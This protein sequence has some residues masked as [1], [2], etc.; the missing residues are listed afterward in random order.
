M[1]NVKVTVLMSVYN[2]E[3]YLREAM[4]SVLNQT[5]MDFEFIIV[6]DAS[7]D[8]TVQILKEYAKKDKRIV[9]VHNDKNLGLTKSLNKGI[10][11]AKGEYIARQDADDISVPER[12]RKEIE[13]L[14]NHRNY[15]V[16][17]TFVKILNEDSKIIRSLD[18]PI[19]DI[20][21]RESFR[22]DNCIAHGSVIIRK[23][24]L[25]DVG[26]YDESIARAQDYELWL[27]LAGKYRLA[28][29]PEYLYMLRKHNE[30]IEAKHIVEQKISVVLAM[31]KN[32]A[33]KVE[34]ATRHFIDII[35]R[36]NFISKY[37]LL[38]IVFRFINILTFNQIGHSTQYNVL[39]RIRFSR[40]INKILED[41]KTG[42]I[43]FENAKLGLKE[44]IDRRLV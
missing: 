3:K 42:K 19:E 14:E 41:F 28:N 10:K 35:L 9:L 33:L 6:N 18:R 12:L 16:V 44:I 43:N 37:K 32:N 5:F 40:K 36:N 15:A 22:R 24:C 26:S 21:I 7:T 4:N 38:T 8:K 29:I 27:R 25:Q 31:V 17:G 20:Q 30:S 11:M 13:F 23:K 34:Q 2:G 39:Y 1:K